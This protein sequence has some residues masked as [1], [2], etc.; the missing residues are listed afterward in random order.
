[1]SQEEK[2]KEQMDDAE[3]EG[4]GFDEKEFMERVKTNMQTMIDD[5]LPS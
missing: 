3:E 1:M 4:E 5:L 2:T